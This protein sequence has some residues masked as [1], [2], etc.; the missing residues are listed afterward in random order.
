VDAIQ[1]VGG[2]DMTGAFSRRRSFRAK[3]K[4]GRLDLEAI[5]QRAAGVST[6]QEAL[7]K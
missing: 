2:G 7:K 3:V 1:V 6:E 4:R 5:R